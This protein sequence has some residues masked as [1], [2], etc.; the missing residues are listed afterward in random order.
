MFELRNY[1]NGLFFTFFF[2]K[3]YLLFI[4]KLNYFC[5]HSKEF[6]NAEFAFEELQVLFLEIKTKLWF[7]PHEPIAN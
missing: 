3:Y 7:S 2:F 1:I 6:K 5:T 4:T